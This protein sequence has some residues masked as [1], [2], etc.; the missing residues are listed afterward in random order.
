MRYEEPK[1]VIVSRATLAVQS[2]GKG[3]DTPFDSKPDHTNGTAYE[4]DE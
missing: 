1:V 4:A 2:M 3:T